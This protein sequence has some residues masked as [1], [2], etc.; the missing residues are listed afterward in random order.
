[1]QDVVDELP[2]YDD[3]DLDVGDLGIK[4]KRWY[5]EGDERFDDSG[6]FLDCVL[7]GIETRTPPL[8]GVP[9]TM[10]ALEQQT[11][12][13]AQAVDRRGWRLVSI[14]W[15]PYC[16][17]YTAS[18]AYNAWELQ[19]REAH[20]EYAA[21][22][23][24]MLSYG[25]DL[26]LSQPGASDADAVDLARKLTF[27]SP[28]LV[29]LSFSSPF[30]YG[31]PASMFSVR[32][33]H[34]TGRRAA[35]RAFVDPASPLLMGHQE[36]PPLIHAARVPAERG[37]VE[38]KAFDALPSQ[39]AYPSLLAL[40][41]GL[42]LDTNLLGRADV[43]DAAAHRRAARHAF[44]GPELAEGAA[45]VVDAAARA[46][47]GSPLLDLLHPVAESV[48]SRQTPAHAMLETYELSGGIR[49]PSVG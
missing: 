3:P 47:A 45:A 10:D 46:L 41:A 16:T 39:Q 34:R 23:V 28:L 33:Y 15:H 11:R 20:T 43:P 29:P 36:A 30:Q 44:D 4:A 5:V 42:A 1:M 38:F 2:Q 14:G 12:A 19:F 40:L 48:A 25:P 21:P 9:A 7:K 27:Y 24:Y 13:L 49:L 26:N 35:A 31:R 32:T 8:L 6:R 37:R 18:P 22:D 17:G